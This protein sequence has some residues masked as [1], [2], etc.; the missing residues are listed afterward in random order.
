LDTN[1]NLALLARAV[2][3]PGARLALRH[4]TVNATQGK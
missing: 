1:E 4:R 3:G 2:M